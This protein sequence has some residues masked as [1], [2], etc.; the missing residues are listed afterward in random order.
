M[1]WVTGTSAKKPG[2]SKT[3]AAAMVPVARSK[4]AGTATAHNVNAQ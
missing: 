2:W 3:A 1:G 4:K